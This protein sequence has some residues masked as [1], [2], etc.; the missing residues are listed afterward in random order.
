MT[1]CLRVP[2]VIKDRGDHVEV[3][4]VQFG[5]YFTSVSRLRLSEESSRQVVWELTATKAPSFWEFPL[6][7]GSN[8]AIFEGIVSGSYEVVTPRNARS[9]FLLRG[10]TYLLEVWNDSGL[11]RST[12]SIK[13]K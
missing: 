13:L 8:P 7:P 9:F 4:V 5:E 2:L 12:A 10:K 11:R 3:R 1:A 6:R